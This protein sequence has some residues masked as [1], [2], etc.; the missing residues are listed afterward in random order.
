MFGVGYAVGY[1]TTGTGLSGQWI[2]ANSFYGVLGTVKILTQL[3]H[4]G[5]NRLIKSQTVKVCLTNSA[6]WVGGGNICKTI[7]DG[8]TC[9]H[10]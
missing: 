7:T 8:S 2:T 6:F 3:H 10:L 9:R 4:H 1:A 5:S